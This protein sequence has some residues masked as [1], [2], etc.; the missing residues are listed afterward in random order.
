M[1]L[2]GQRGQDNLIISKWKMSGFM[3]TSSVF[4]N[5]GSFF[6]IEGLTYCVNVTSFQRKMVIFLPR[7]N[8]AAFMLHLKMEVATSLSE[9]QF[10]RNGK[11]CVANPSQEQVGTENWRHCSPLFPV[12]RYQAQ[13]LCLHNQSQSYCWQRDGK[14]NW[15][16]K[17]RSWR[18][19]LV[20]PMFTMCES[21]S[22]PQVVE[23]SFSEWKSTGS[24]RNWL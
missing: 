11:N 4:P 6:S 12:I 9:S 14:N 16:V 24:T 15:I 5:H 3:R 21:F 19:R 2:F 23:K 10:F 22:F 20:F 1:G 8:L 13:I 7:S 18:F 17:K